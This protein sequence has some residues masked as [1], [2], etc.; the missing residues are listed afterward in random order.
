[1]NMCSDFLKLALELRKRGDIKAAKQALE[2]ACE[3]GDRLAKRHK[4]F[5]Q[6]HGGFGYYY[7]PP[8]DL[9]DTT[10]LLPVEVIKM[11]PLD[12]V[13]TVDLYP[14]YTFGGNRNI[15]R[16]ERVMYLTHAANEGCA[17]ACH[18]LYYNQ[19]ISVEERNKYLEVAVKQRHRAA[20]RV[21]GHRL[22][23]NINTLKRGAILYAKSNPG[24]FLYDKIRKCHAV[25]EVTMEMYFYG[26]YIFKGFIPYSGFRA[27]WAKR[28]YTKTNYWAKQAVYCWL[29]IYR[30]FVCKDVGKIIA[31]LVWNN[32]CYYPDVWS[33]LTKLN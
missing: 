17:T 29:L 32:R 10:D 2:N 31:K 26:K 3:Q 30:R 27:D 5:A 15:T 9:W 22:L 23:G 8:C 21:L 14:L 18:E 20:M 16:D 25:E 12:S 11:L 33:E 19:S 6:Q 7:Y 13:D 1:M 28:I 4:A 24:E